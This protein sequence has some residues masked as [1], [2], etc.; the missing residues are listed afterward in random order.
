[1]LQHA[2]VSIARDTYLHC[3][4]KL[5]RKSY[6]SDRSPPAVRCDDVSTHGALSPALQTLGSKRVGDCGFE[7]LTSSASR[8]Y[9]RLLGFS[10]ACKIPAMS[11]VSTSTLVLIFQEIG[12]GCCTERQQRSDSQRDRVPATCALRSATRRERTEQ[13]TRSQSCPYTTRMSPRC[14]RR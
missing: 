10:G 5:W 8:K 11:R 12:S 9:D 3:R 2:S 13:Q 6:P 1:M 14:T 7:Q 4:P